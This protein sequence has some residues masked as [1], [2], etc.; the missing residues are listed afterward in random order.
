M[1]SRYMNKDKLRIVMKSFVTSQFGYYPLVWMFHSK[2]LNNRINKIH[3]RALRLV[4]E[5][6]N[7][8]F[9]EH[10]I[11]DGSVTIHHQNLQLLVTE[12][13]KAINNISPAITNYS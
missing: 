13:C 8:T 9:Q 2:G 5:E 12:I 4:F 6:H 11:K 1:V 7:S 10:L 3:T